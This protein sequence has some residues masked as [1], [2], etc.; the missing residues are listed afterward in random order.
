MQGDDTRREKKEAK[1]LRRSRDSKG[2]Q[3][4]LRGEWEIRK[5]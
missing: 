4:G 1:E 3:N 5:K 2:I